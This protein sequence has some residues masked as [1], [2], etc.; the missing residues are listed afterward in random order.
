MIE[1]CPKKPQSRS[2]NIK[3][4][5]GGIPPDIAC[6]L[7]WVHLLIIKN[8]PLQGQTTGLNVVAITDFH[9]LDSFNC[10]FKLDSTRKWIAQVTIG[11]RVL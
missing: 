3:K 4:F 7:L 10:E 8:P 6:A 5:L 2:L 1:K 9:D 11:I